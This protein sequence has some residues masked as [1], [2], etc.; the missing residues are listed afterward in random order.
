[1]SLSLR[2]KLILSFL[3]AIVLAIGSI[4]TVL[5]ININTYSQNSFE[6]SSVI[7]LERIED[8]IREFVTSAKNNADYLAR[9]LKGKDASGQLSK[10]FGSDARPKIDPATMNPFELNLYNSYADITETHP[11]YAA[12]YLAMNDGGFTMYPPDT[13]KNYDPRKRPWY[14]ETQASSSNNVVSK[15]Y[16]GTSGEAMSTITTKVRGAS[17]QVVGVIG[18]DINL[19]TLTEVTANIKLGRT[20][21]VL[22]MQSDGVILSDPAAPKLNFKNASETDV[23]ALKEIAG[24]DNGIIRTSIDGVP[25]LISVITSKATGWKLVYI[26]DKAEVLEAANVMLKRVLLIGAGLAVLLLIGALLIA[27][28]FVRPV[29]LL[30]TGAQ[31]VSKG[32]YEAVPDKRFFKGELLTLHTSFSEMVA[33]LVKVIGTA[34]SKTKEA[35]EKSQQAEEAMH[36]AEQAKEKAERAR[37]EGMLHAAGELEE[38][39]AQV[40]AASQELS[41]Q[42]QEAANGS[43]IQRDRTTEAATAME[44][45]NASVLEVASNASQAAESADDAK[46]EAGNGSDIVANVVESINQVDAKANAMADSLNTLGKQAEGIGQVM[47]VITDIADQTN[48]LALNAAIEAARAG[49]AGRGFAVVADEVRKLA[50]KTMT[51]TKEV[52]QSVA[53][54]QEGTKLAISDMGSTTELISTSTGYAHQAGGALQSILTIVDSTADQVRA[55]AT[56]SEEQSAVSEQINSSTEEVN[57]IAAQTAESMRHSSHAVGELANLAKNLDDLIVQL[58][59]G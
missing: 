48:L 56:A 19:A 51:A 25:K 50:E 15:A 43:S 49:D 55:I 1:M 20:G 45:M 18:I 57:R 39:V 27:Q 46:K 12:A 30:V 22:L 33:E 58:K 44:Q 23:P 32:D 5:Y 10:Y 37:R 31:A 29:K 24:V 7:Q 13:L 38:I 28:G 17:G 41:G 36:A 54:I 4:S 3:A 21:Y 26:T 34:E 40:T 35:E 16:V 8:F 52:G 6:Q 53:A 11:N 59:N 42:I 47:T 2:S 9:Q 14:K